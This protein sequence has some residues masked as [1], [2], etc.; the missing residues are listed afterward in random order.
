M[1]SG[2]IMRILAQA[3]TCSPWEKPDD[4]LAESLE[5]CIFLFLPFTIF[6]VDEISF[7]CIAV[8]VGAPRNWNKGDYDLVVYSGA[9]FCIAI[10]L[11]RFSAFLILHAVDHASCPFSPH[12][13]HRRYCPVVS[14]LHSLL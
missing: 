8:S 10:S 4:K 7:V 9:R 2:F 6:H 14:K 12:T 5:L 11:F 1:F 3:N 13:A